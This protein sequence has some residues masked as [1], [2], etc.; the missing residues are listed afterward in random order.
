MDSLWGQSLGYLNSITGLNYFTHFPCYGSKGI[1]IRLNQ[2]W[3]LEV[4]SLGT[5][6]VLGS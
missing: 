6:L 2:A 1:M 4:R 3:N 5:Y